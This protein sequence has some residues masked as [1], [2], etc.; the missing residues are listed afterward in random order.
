M[1]AVET[2]ALLALIEAV[3]PDH[4]GHAEVRRVVFGIAAAGEVE[5]PGAAEVILGAG[6]ADRGVIVV[7][8]EIDLQFALA[9]PAKA[10]DTPR[11][12]GADIVTMTGNA[13]Q[14]DMCVT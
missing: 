11:K 5:V 14:D 10:V 2:E 7:A 12:V 8:V 9:P 1:P 6:A 3:G 4:L 13:V